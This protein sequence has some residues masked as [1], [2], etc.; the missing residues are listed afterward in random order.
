MF[1]HK[2]SPQ[3]RFCIT[4][5]AGA[6]AELV[7]VPGT[8]RFRTDM[9]GGNMTTL[10]SRLRAGVLGIALAGGAAVWPAYAC[11][12]ERGEGSKQSDIG[13]VTGLAVGAAAGGPVGAVLGAA[14]GALLGDRYHRQ[15][16]S[17]AALAADLDHSEAERSRLSQSVAQLDQTLQQTEELGLDVS[18]RTN[19][20]SITTQAMPPLLKLGA[21]VAAMPQARVR[22]AGYADPRGSQA[23]NSEL[24]LRRAQGVAA[25][26][27]AAGVA[28]ERILIEAH[29]KTES[30]SA[31]G[32][33]DGYAFERR[34]TVRL[35]VP[36]PGEVA[37]RDQGA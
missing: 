35:E 9:R 2:S 27:M 8:K 18:F 22:I 21:L 10:T 3:C 15:A 16:Q 30:T 24:S 34:V 12:D 11:G 28:P 1:R 6:R 33:L 36:A 13:A 17:S 4:S 37:R 25:V 26:L 19:D 29:G 31:D 20:D 14:A 23:Y 5:A 7:T 32:D